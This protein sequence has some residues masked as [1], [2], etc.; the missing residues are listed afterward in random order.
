MARPGLAPAAASAFPSSPTASSATSGAGCC[1]RTAASRAAKVGAE[2]ATPAAHMW[3]NADSAAAVL[4][5]AQA[6]S[7]TASKTCGANRGRCRAAMSD[8][9]RWRP[10]GGQEEPAM[11][12]QACSRNHRA[13]ASGAGE[14]P[15]S[16]VRRRPRHAAPSPPAPHPP[17]PSCCAACGDPAPPAAQQ[18]WGA[19][20]GPA[21][22]GTHP[23][24]HRTA[25]SCAAGKRRGRLAAA[26][27]ATQL[28][29]A[30]PPCRPTVVQQGW[31]RQ[32]CRLA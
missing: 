20:L 21:C 10:G 2:G 12:S 1:C 28:A 6:R 9:A 22:C 26:R 4:P 32:A 3:P 18:V 29:G 24:P 15:A 8:G 16:P 27:G 23:A 25:R 14:R 19:A 5:A 11:P 30:A 31:A 7:I 17:P 13:S